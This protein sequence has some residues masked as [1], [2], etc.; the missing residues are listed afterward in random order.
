[1]GSITPPGR[2]QPRLFRLRQ[3]RRRPVLAAVLVAAFLATFLIDWA[4]TLPAFSA[5]SAPATS[6]SCTVSPDN[7]CIQGTITDSEREPA[8]DVDVDV[9]GPGSPRLLVSVLTTFTTGSTT[10]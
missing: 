3:A 6:Q 9:A 10:A 7:G 2:A 4:V 5:T 8:E 1:M